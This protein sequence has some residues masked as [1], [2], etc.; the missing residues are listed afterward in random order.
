MGKGHPVTTS[1][2]SLKE[3]SKTGLMKHRRGVYPCDLNSSLGTSVLIQLGAGKEKCSIQQ[4]PVRLASGEHPDELVAESTG[5]QQG[6]FVRP[7]MTLIIAAA[8]PTPD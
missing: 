8:H 6:E 2:C 5:P 7:S 3:K 1:V 4:H